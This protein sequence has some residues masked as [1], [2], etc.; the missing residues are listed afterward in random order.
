MYFSFHIL[1]II[2]RCQETLLAGVRQWI[3]ALYAKASGG[4]WALKTLIYGI[5]YPRGIRDCEFASVH[6]PIECLV[7]KIWLIHI[8]RGKW[9]TVKINT[10]SFNLVYSPKW[11]IK[12][13]TYGFICQSITEA[14]NLLNLTWR[15]SNNNYLLF[16]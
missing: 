10:D 5:Y 16:G 15:K 6:C 13:K 11:I 7:R 3:Y 8:P 9:S 1:G 4:L 14:E 12:K 2:S